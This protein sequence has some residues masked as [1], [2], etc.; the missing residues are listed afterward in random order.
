VNLFGGKVEGVVDCVSKPFRVRDLLARVH[1]Q[2]QLGKRRLKLEEDFEVR[3]HE[4][5]L[6]TDLSPVSVRDFV[7]AS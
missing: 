3:S 5:Q 4:L 2:V 1:L 7:L 6:L